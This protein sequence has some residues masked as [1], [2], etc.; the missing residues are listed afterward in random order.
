MTNNS[1]PLI[2]EPE[3]LQTLLPDDNLILVAVC[4][5]Q[6]YNSGHLPG[7]VLIEPAELVSGVKPATGK[8]PSAD[9]LSALFSRIGLTADKHVVAYDDEGG[10]WAGRL[11]WTLDV[12]GHEKSSYLNGGLIAWAR[13]GFALDDQLPSVAATEFTAQIDHG[14]IAQLEDVLQ[15]IGSDNSVVWDARARQE[16]DGIK[17]TALRNGH[18]PGA[19]N[20][21]WL[22]LM[23]RDN[24]LRL[25]PLTEISQTLESLGVSKDKAVITHCQTHHRSGL[26]YLVGK[27]LGLNIKAYDGSWSEWGNADDTPIETTANR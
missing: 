11:I 25:K 6:I 17:V 26:T 14:Q 2:I 24:D 4:S 12:L 10:G 9:R 21:D 22:D 7:S 1:L 27:A 3:T 13:A 18:I 20:L 19:V 8:I 23:D 16:Y 5:A 15:Q